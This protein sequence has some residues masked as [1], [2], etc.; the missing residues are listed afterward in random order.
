MDKKELVN[1]FTVD[2]PNVC[3]IGDIHGEFQSLNALMKKSNFHDTAFI[4]CGD[5]GLGFEKKEHYS[6]I[7]NRLSKTASKMNNEFLFIRGNHDDSRYFSKRLIN[8]KCFKTI[9]DYSV[10]EKNLYNIL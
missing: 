10:I 7:F 8:R 2:K 5:I 1:I 9:P 3:F 6:Q 4:V